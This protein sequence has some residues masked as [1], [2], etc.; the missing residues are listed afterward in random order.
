MPLFAHFQKGI[1][2]VELEQ[3]VTPSSLLDSLEDY[4]KVINLRRTIAYAEH[5]LY[6]QLMLQQDDDLL[7]GR[8]CLFPPSKFP[9]LLY[10]QPAQRGLYL[11]VISVEASRR[12]GAPFPVCVVN[13][14]EQFDF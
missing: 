9:L 13:T 1:L 2:S 12:R 6:R 7:V 4:V 3:T 5:E 10:R 14:D 11:Y 8:A